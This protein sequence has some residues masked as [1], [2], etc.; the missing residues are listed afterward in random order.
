MVKYTLIEVFKLNLHKS[1][2]NKMTE[3]SKKLEGE[4]INEEITAETP[5]QEIDYNS[6][7]IEELF[8]QTLELIKADNIYSVAKSID[9]IKAI[10][11][12]KVNA[13]KELHKS[14]FLKNE[15]I[16]E[17]YKY[18]HPL[19]KDY[20]KIYGEFRKKKA[21]HREKIELD[22]VKNLK[23]KTQII[24]DIEALVSDEETIKET[25]EKFRALQDKWRS[26]G[27]VSIGYRN[28]I[29]KS[30]H[31]QV[32]KFYDYIKINNELRDLDFEKNYKQKA[33]MCQDA[34]SLMKEKSINKVHNELQILH[35]KWK[36][37]GPVKREL[38]EEIWNRFKAATRELHKKRNEHF[39]ELKAKGEESFKNKAAICEKIN[40]LNEKPAQ[41]H[42][43]WNKL[44]IEVQELE[45]E[46]K[47]Q[48]PLS[49][50]DNKKA[51]NLLRETLSNFYSKKNDFYKDK[52]QENKIIMQQKVALCEKAEALTSANSSWKERTEK[53]LKLQEDWKK[54]G[55]LP[56]IQSDK[57]WK[58]FRDSL[59][60]FYNNKK[61]F[62]K[63]L[64]KE[65]SDNLTKKE[66]YL[67][68]VSTFKLAE[69]KEE[70][71]NSLENFQKEWRSIG[72]VPR[73]KN[74]IDDT[75]KK[76]IDG[77]Y[78]KMK[79]DKKELNTIKFNNKLENL[80]SKAD[81]FAIDKEKQFFRNK[82]NDLVKEVN[83]YET[84]ISFFGNSKGA[85][86]M[87]AQIEKKIE[88]GKS[89]IDSFKHKL[90]Q[91]NNL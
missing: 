6:F 82:I 2:L 62:F 29:W 57:I 68:T 8:Q 11:Y 34:E 88:K 49:K 85:D 55:Y 27:E 48:A 64:D 63:A 45:K 53:V 10:F 35:E 18:Y 87:K 66:D 75:F 74:K 78:T 69:D 38:R 79:I 4:I 83:Q 24:K 43:D 65:K 40:T 31:H 52:K 1:K 46:W 15:G 86:K 70:N 41:S 20:K 33:Q 72:D 73:N 26:T 42:N 44:T 39:L 80:K 90:K 22:F 32:E 37:I 9:G 60:N 21:E 77:F 56:K 19:E 47:K 51:W 25:F 67:K 81:S 54:S 7:T 84:N 12:K 61:N 3:D 14:E 17:E 13:E 23:I 5:I 91:L 71:F 28:D 16:E 50:E 30:Y 76:L 36:N 59:D 89:E 58:R